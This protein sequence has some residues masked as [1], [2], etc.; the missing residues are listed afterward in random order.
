MFKSFLQFI[1]KHVK[2]SI[3]SAV[4]LSLLASSGYYFAVEQ[5]G[6][7]GVFETVGANFEDSR[8]FIVDKFQG[9]QTKADPTKI[10]LG[11]NPNGQNTIIND[12]DRIGSRNFGYEVLGTSTTT[13]QAIKTLHTFR[14]R[15]GENIL[16]R[17]RGTYVEMF[18]EENSLWESVT[19]TA[20]SSQEYGFA[21]YNINSDL[22]SF[23][24][25]G[26][27]VDPFSRWNGAHTT[28]TAAIAIGATSISVGDASGFYV[29]GTLRYCDT[30]LLYTAKTATTFTVN[31]TTV[32]CASGRTIMQAAEEFPSFPRGNI[33][34]AEN[35]RIFIAGVTTTPQAIFFS[36]Y[37]DPTTWLTSLITNSTADAA[38]VFNLGE[39]GGAV[40]GMSRDESSIYFFKKN[41]VRKAT[42]SD[43]LYTLGTLKPFDGK[44]QTTGNTNR[45][46]VFTGGNGTFFVTPD[47]QIMSLQRVAQVDYPQLIPISYT[48]QPTAD[49][50]DFSSGAGIFW[51]QSAY[52]SAKSTSDSVSPDVILIFNSAVN[53]WESP[54]VGVSASDFAVYDDGSGEALYFGDANTTNV[55]KFTSTNISDNDNAF[56]SNWRSKQFNAKDFGFSQSEMVEMDSVFIEGYISEN[57][58]LTISLLLDEDGYTQQFSTTIDGATDTGLIFS[59]T[60]YNI[61]GLHPFGFLHIGSSDAAGKRKFRVYLS[62]DFRSLPF[63]NAQVEF[64]SESDGQEWEVT[65]FGLKVRPAAQ[66][67]KRTL[68]KA[69]K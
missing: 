48:I 19:S 23:V 35:N 53:V 37:G 69:F 55:Y 31:T 25:F 65:V 3:A 12:G 5:R 20:T 13:E 67:E 17:T 29:T 26:N 21:D 34:L 40:T 33:Y 45:K 36:K 38:G 56:T 32:A 47:N 50:V 27:A 7:L 59:S 39:G 22:R 41:I 9:Y 24:Y 60:P 18:D 16:I 6:S 1:K 30:N 68:Y 44:S 51:K 49:T 63:Y 11:A 54:V 57:T 62:K 14:K 46:L 52:F 15:S 2:A 58:D 28:S 10:P 42:L 66:K 43:S 61:F 8:W 64:A 4:L